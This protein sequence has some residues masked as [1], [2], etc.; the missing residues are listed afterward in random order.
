MSSFTAI[1]LG[2]ENIFSGYQIFGLPS[3]RV[4]QFL[5][6]ILIFKSFL[7]TVLNISQHLVFKYFSLAVLVLTFFYYLTVLFNLET[8]TYDVFKTG[9]RLISF[10]IIFYL[11]Y[12][13]L[14]KNYKYLN[15]ILLIQMISF[16]IAFFQFFATPF[17]DDAWAIKMNYFLNNIDADDV[18]VLEQ[19]EGRGRIAGIYSFVITLN[20]ALISAGIISLYMFLKT[21]KTIYKY[22]F[23]FMGLVTLMTLTRSA[24]LSY[25]VMFIWLGVYLYKSYS[26]NMKIF[27]IS[28][29]FI[30]IGYIFYEVFNFI[31]SFNT[32]E[33]I[34][35]SRVF[36]LGEGSA[37]GRIPLWI[38]GITALLY[39]PLR[40]I[41]GSYLEIQQVMYSIFHNE[42]ILQFSPHN[43][44]ITIGMRYSLFSLIFFI[45][46]IYIVIKIIKN[47]I[48]DKVMRGFFYISL[49]GYFIN[50]FFH[51]NILF[52]QDFFIITFLAIIAYEVKIQNKAKYEKN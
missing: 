18:L 40:F 30:V 38:T 32:S 47:K 41:S 10:I 34:L 11:T 37:S 6:F 39:D 13:M 21:N 24:I 27:V 52:V 48:E 29:S 5:L 31:N 3:Y 42:H 19:L 16:T 23:V 49:I 1:T 20:Y 44:L 15:I 9:M 36:D 8:S 35:V 12:Y 22:L 46:F 43:G 2:I 4:V 17:T 28:S 50:I 51:N 7:K 25:V 33:F 45:I 14:F 26:K